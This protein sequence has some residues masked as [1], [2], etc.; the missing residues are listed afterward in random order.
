MI[1]AKATVVSSGSDSRQPA[2][3]VLDGISTS[4]SSFTGVAKTWLRVDI[5][6][7]LYIRQ[8]RLLFGGNSYSGAGVDVYVGRGLRNNGLHENLRCHSVLSV[9]TRFQWM[10]YTCQQPAIGQYIYIEKWRSSMELC[11]IAAFYGNVSVC[12]CP[13]VCVSLS[14]SVCAR[15]IA[16]IHTVYDT[17]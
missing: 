8:V 12:L 17:T 5:Q 7:I 2:V 15:A 1:D 4:C 10:K 3:L 6:T 11:E 13:Y 14:G 9:V 16:Y